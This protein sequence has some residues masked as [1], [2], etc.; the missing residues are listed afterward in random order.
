M[1][2][3]PPIAAAILTAVLWASGRLQRPLQVAAAVAVGMLL[4]FWLGSPYD[5]LW[6]VGVVLNSTLAIA[7]AI[8]QKLP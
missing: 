6:L 5:M 1:F 8:R 3:V 2:L 4:Q 7:L